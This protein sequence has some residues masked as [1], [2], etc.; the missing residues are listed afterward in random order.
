[1]VSMRDTKKLASIILAS[2]LLVSIARSADAQ[3]AASWGLDRINQRS[4]P[5]DNDRAWASSGRGVTVYVVDS[6]IYSAHTEFAGRILP[7]YSVINDGRGTE[8]CHGHGTH[9][10]GTVGGTT[11]GVA[12]SVSFVPV[13]VADCGG[14]AWAS[15]IASGVRWAVQH[16]QPGQPA[17]MNISQSGGLSGNLNMA[18]Q[19]AV[20]DGI[21]VVVA[22][23]N[24]AAD[25][26]RY[27]PGAA[28]AAI[29]VGA[30]EANDSRLSQSNFGSCVDIFAPGA[31]IFSAW[32]TGPS[33]ARSFKGTSFATPH[34]SGAAA[35]L[36]ERDP[37][38]TPQEVTA[39]LLSSAT[40][41]AVTSAGTGSPDALLYVDLS[42]APPASSTSVPATAAPTTT[43]PPATTTT[44]LAPTTTM[45]TTTTTTPQKVQA[46]T[47]SRA[48]LGYYKIDV[49]G[50]QAAS[51]IGVRAVDASRRPPHTMTW[52]VDTDDRGSATFFVRRDLSRYVASVVSN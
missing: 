27:S 8:D 15:N 33:D 44:T 1:M 20:D 22:A 4:L 38:L 35:L 37:S 12:P 29:T 50:A 45:P 47:V 46:V 2:S 42:A 17:V 7:G 14:A 49:T 36:L 31:W 39:R 19:E 28:P 40:R 26:C 6:G 32:N 18:I 13:R 11:F 9:V 48:G 5:L 23:G 30:T 51:K 43:A 16:H 52:L 3:P 10:A 25:A 34:V 41:G 24:A 21:V